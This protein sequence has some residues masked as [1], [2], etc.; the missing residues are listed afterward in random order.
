VTLPFEAARQRSP[1]RE[2]LTDDKSIQ[3]SRAERAMS[4]KRISNHS[5]SKIIKVYLRE[6]RVLRG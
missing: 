5:P 6:L 1:I 4:F 3:A 2:W